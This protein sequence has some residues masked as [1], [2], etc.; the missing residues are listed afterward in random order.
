MRSAEAICGDKPMLSSNDTLRTSGKGCH[1]AYVCGLFASMVI[2]VVFPVQNRKK[3]QVVSG[4]VIA[5]IPQGANGPS[6]ASLHVARLMISVEIMKVGVLIGRVQED[7][8]RLVQQ[9]VQGPSL[10]RD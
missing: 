5:G 3:C 9:A 1:P 4:V 2:I 7:E 8:V 6:P 10:L